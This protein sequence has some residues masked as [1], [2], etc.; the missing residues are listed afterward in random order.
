MERISPER[1]S[2]GLQL[3]EAET[4]IGVSR[5]AVSELVRI[6]PVNDIAI[7]WERQQIEEA[8]LARNALRGQLEAVKTSEAM[9]MPFSWT[10]R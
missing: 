6:E 10:I 1:R 5:R 7:A 3:Y 4:A 9:L 2:L 8:R